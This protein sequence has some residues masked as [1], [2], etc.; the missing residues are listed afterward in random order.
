MDLVCCDCVIADCEV[1]RAE[2]SR[3]PEIIFVSKKALRDDDDDMQPPICGASD[4]TVIDVEGGRT[5]NVSKN[6]TSSDKTTGDS[7]IG[8]A[9]R[10]GSMT[11]NHGGNAFVAAV[12]MIYQYSASTARFDETMSTLGST[13]PP[14]CLVFMSF[15]PTAHTTNHKI[16]QRLDRMEK[17]FD[18][19][20]KKTEARFKS[21]DERFDQMDERF[22]CFDKSLLKIVEAVVSEDEMDR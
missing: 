7:S 13:C 6:E 18:S 10:V 9:G 15:L 20:E 14:C 4:A 19:F 21:I 3:C 12:G 8:L 1:T 22:D 17:R 16:D 11:S 2:R 5:D